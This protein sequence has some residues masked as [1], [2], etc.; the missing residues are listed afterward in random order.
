MSVQHLKDYTPSFSI[1]AFPQSENLTEL[2]VNST[3]TVDYL[4]TAHTNATGF[5]DESFP[6][7]AGCLS[8]PLAVGYQTGQVN[9]SDFA[10]SEGIL[11]SC[12]ASPFLLTSFQIST[13]MNYVDVAFPNWEGLQ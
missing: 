6:R 3:F 11:P 4:L 5:Y 2:S 8:F 1:F 7:L 13:S 12:P 10:G 9:A